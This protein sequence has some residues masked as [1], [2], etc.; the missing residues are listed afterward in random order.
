LGDRIK[1]N[2]SA[3]GVVLEVKKDKSINYLECILYDGRLTNK[4]E[5]A[6]ASFDDTIVTKIRT[7]EEV[8]PL[9]K[10]YETKEKVE[11]ATGLKLQITSKEEI[12]PGMPFRVVEDNLKQIEE[13][14]S[15]EISEEIQTDE[16]GISVKADSLGSLEA[17]LVLLKE[18]GIRVIKAKI[19]PITKKDIY[20]ANSLD[21]ADRVILGFNV[22]LSEEIKE[23]DE[24][25]KIKIVTN[26]VVYQII[27]EFEEWKIEKIKEMER[28]KLCE[29]VD[30]TK[31][32]ILDFVFRN[33][34]PAVFGVKVLGGKLKRGCGLINKNDEKI[35]HVKE[36]EKDRKGVRAADMDDEVSVSLPGVNFE[37]QLETGEFLYSNLAESQFRKFK[38]CKELLT[39]EEKKTLME[40]AE[41]KRK[42]K[43][44]WGI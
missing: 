28:K 35:A 1:I 32:E 29:L 11:A 10:G 24:L 40:I 7:I 17:L 15:R 19:G 25:K 23:M 30:I 12:L 16:E 2:D 3:K 5:I 41:I 38:E 43:A 33:S 34:N 6:I 31:V 44:T 8:L 37:R 36:I 18:K 21:E 22:D 27:K 4:D 13:E 20:F 39:V 14:F 9:N 42:E 26:P